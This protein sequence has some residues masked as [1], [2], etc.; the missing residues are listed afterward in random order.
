MPVA[1]RKDGSVADECRQAE[2][3]SQPVGSEAYSRIV[4]VSQDSNL[5]RIVN[6]GMW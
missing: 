6:T 3:G 4:T 1:F 5:D 2:A